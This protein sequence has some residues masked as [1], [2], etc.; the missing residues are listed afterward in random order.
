[1]YDFSCL[2]EK[3]ELENFGKKQRPNT[4]SREVFYII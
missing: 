4:F 1:M 2:S 3:K